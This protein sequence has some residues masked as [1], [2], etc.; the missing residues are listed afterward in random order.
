MDLPANSSPIYWNAMKLNNPVA[1]LW[2]SP[3]QR[4]GERARV[5]LHHLWCYFCLHNL[6]IGNCRTVVTWPLSNNLS[7]LA[8]GLGQCFRTHFWFVEKWRALAD[9][10]VRTLHFW[11]VGN[12]F[13]FAFAFTLH[14]APYPI[15]PYQTWFT[16]ICK[17]FLQICVKLL[18]NLWKMNPTKFFWILVSLI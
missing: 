6:L 8:N 5:K 12:F 7:N 18:T 11:N 14:F 9:L 10:P 17:I 3:R 1:M 13:A 15:L 16:H 4:R 2:C